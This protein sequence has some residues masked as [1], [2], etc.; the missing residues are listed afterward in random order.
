MSVAPCMESPCSSDVA[1]AYTDT[2]A[3]DDILVVTD[4]GVR[5][6]YGP[7]SPGGDDRELSNEEEAINNHSTRSSWSYQDYQ[8]RMQAPRPQGNMTPV[9]SEHH[10]A[11]NVIRHRQQIDRAATKARQAG[12]YRFQ[13]RNSFFAFHLISSSAFLLVIAIGCV[14]LHEV[15]RSTT[16]WCTSAVDAT[17]YSRI[18]AISALVDAILVVPAL[19]PSYCGLYRV[20]DARKVIRRP[21]LQIC[22][23]IVV[24]QLVIYAVQLLLW[25]VKMIQKPDCSNGAPEPTEWTDK[26]IIYVKLWS[27]LPAGLLIWWQLTSFCLFRTHLKLQI[28]SANDSKHSAN[29]KG[30]IKRLFSLPAF[31]RRNQ[32]IRDLRADLFKAAMTGDLPHAEEL[33]EKATRLLGREFAGKKLYHEPRMW[34][35]SFARSRKNPLHVAVARGDV[36]MM[37][38]FLR[39]RFDVNALDKVS[40]VNFN[41]GLFF[42]LTRLLVKTQ[43]FLQPAGDSIFK[44][45]LV[46]PLHVAVQQGQVEAVRTLLQHNANVNKLPRASFYY[47]AA[48][49]PAIF[50]ADHVQVL[51][52]LLAHNTNH[53]YVVERGSTVM[54]PYQRNVLTLRTA[55]SALLVDN[56][57]DVALTPLH[58]AAAADNEVAVLSLL[59]SGVAPDILGELVTGI[60]HRT[61][62]HW[63]AVSGSAKSARH[64]LVHGADPNAVDSYGRTPLHWA[65][66]N[67]HVD[68]VLALLEFKADP[69]VQDANGYPVLCVAAEAEGVSADLVS[70]LIEAG[71]DLTFQTMHGGNT[72]L[73]IALINENRLTAVA[74]L[75][76]GADIMATNHDGRRAVDCTTS[77]ELQFA[78]K[79]E[80]GSRDVMISYTHAHSPV[81]K[82]VR[83][84]LVEHA[85]MTCWMDTMDPSGIGGGAFPDAYETQVGDRGVQVSGGQKQR[86]AIARAI[87]RDPEVLLLD[88]ATSALDN[89]SERIVQASLD[90]LLQLKRR[91]TVI[92]AHRLSTIRNADII[93]VTH[94]GKIAEQGTHDELMAIPN[95]KYFNL[96]QRQTNH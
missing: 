38:L 49:K 66:R 73:H 64:L 60:H 29:L 20:S 70:L 61:A 86:I 77:T 42:K 15:T 11:S 84:Y 46:T 85:R 27:I 4:R 94:D 21:F 24:A 68:V 69:N 25:L 6:Q 51:K 37:E 53:L 59:K 88:E 41:F 48:V 39:F 10:S 1:H 78:V 56:G 8:Q 54:T 44:S 2:H 19:V 9:H 40:R 45:V 79:K 96:V 89:E 72:P 76:N 30:W 92:V 95:G 26:L 52:L 5:I 35:W 50:F 47:P 18:V 12:S 90:A 71:G 28:G 3:S 31:G 7:M 87:L 16:H 81:A 75:R 83:D 62:L 82:A 34:M 63:A 91:T 65:A 80:A 93:A 36:A 14:V 57:G 58:A 22:E 33:L 55:Q 23:I 43:D 13:W 17:Y 32:I 74:L 67:N